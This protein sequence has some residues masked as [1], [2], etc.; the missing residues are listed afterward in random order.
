MQQV[1]FEYIEYYPK[2]LRHHSYLG[3]PSPCMFELLTM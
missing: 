1:I 2:W 3:Y